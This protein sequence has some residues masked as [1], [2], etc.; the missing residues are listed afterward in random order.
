MSPKEG[1]KDGYRRR[2]GCAILGST[3]M[4][5]GDFGSML[6]YDGSIIIR[7]ACVNI[8]II[9]ADTVFT[10]LTILDT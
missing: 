4:N 2:G 7:H 3:S 9:V 10:L 6:V 5:Y 8:Y 1:D